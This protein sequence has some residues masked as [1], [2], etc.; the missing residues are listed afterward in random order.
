MKWQSK[1]TDEKN[2]SQTLYSRHSIE[3]SKNELK[4]YMKNGKK[5]IG[6]IIRCAQTMNTL[7]HMEY[8]RVFRDWVHHY[9]SHKAS[10][11]ILLD[12]FLHWCFYHPSVLYHTIPITLATFYRLLFFQSR[13]T[14]ECV[15]DLKPRYSVRPKRLWWLALNK[16]KWQT[17]D[18]R[19]R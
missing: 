14:L 13:V 19:K 2:I 9:H 8:G 16:Q 3:T 5:W 6:R 15:Y 4:R 1:S 10:V 17:S 12:A 18:K 7:L 11:S